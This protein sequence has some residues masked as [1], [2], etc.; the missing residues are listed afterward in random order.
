MLKIWHQEIC[1]QAPIFNSAFVLR[2]LDPSGIHSQVYHLMQ[3]ADLLSILLDSEFSGL[4][5]SYLLLVKEF[6]LFFSI[7]KLHA[8]PNNINELIVVFI[9]FLLEVLAKFDW[10]ESY[11]KGRNQILQM[12][13]KLLIIYLGD[14]PL[15]A[16]ELEETKSILTDIEALVNEVGSFLYPLFFTGHTVLVI[17][18]DQS[19][20]DLLKK[21]EI[22]KTKIEKHCI[23]VSKIQT[24]MPKKTLENLMNNKADTIIKVKDQFKTIYEELLYLRSF[25]KNIDLQ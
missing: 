25:L 4:V 2:L 12:E 7:P 17:E 13:L 6:R 9:D 22:F 1:L 23:T 19:L 15:Q 14:T 3:N 20:P 5:E 8:T 16:I 11:L 18:I 21:F 10:I 24:D